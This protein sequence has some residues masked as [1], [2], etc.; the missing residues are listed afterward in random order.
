[1]LIILLITGV[2]LLSVS[3]STRVS[4]LELHVASSSD[5]IKK[6][7]LEFSEYDISL[8][9]AVPARKQWLSGIFPPDNLPFAGV[10]PIKEQC[11]LY[12]KYRKHI[13]LEDLDVMCPRPS[14]EVLSSQKA[15]KK[16]HARVKK[17]A[18]LQAAKKLKE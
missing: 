16:Q 11:E 4:N 10:P 5:A 13:P 14:H 8:D 15:D 9:E 7:F 3:T 12:F 17:E 2:S 18:K 1:M 6:N